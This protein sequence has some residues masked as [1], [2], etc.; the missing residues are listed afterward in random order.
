MSMQVDEQR[1]I[2]TAC[3]FFLAGERCTPEIGFAIY[4]M[5]SVSAPV[6]VNYALATEIALKLLIRSYGN[7]PP[8]GADAHNLQKLFECLPKE[9][10]QFLDGYKEAIFDCSEYFV[11]WRYPYEVPELIGSASELRRVFIR[12]YQEIR[13]RKPALSSIYEKNWGHFEP[14]WLWSGHRLD[15]TQQK[16][17]NE[18]P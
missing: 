12:C 10:R 9:G 3:A 6:L 13:R 5:H 11:D 4:P 14:D 2:D 18:Y 15:V 17:A 1:M 7:K 8:R 16:K